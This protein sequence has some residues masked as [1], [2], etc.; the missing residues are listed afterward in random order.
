MTLIALLT[1]RQGKTLIADALISRP[2]PPLDDFVFPTRIYI[3]PGQIRGMPLKPGALRRKVIEISSNLV[4]LWAGDYNEAQRFAERAAEWLNGGTIGESDIVAFLEE[5]YRQRIPNFHAIIIPAH[6]DWFYQ[7]GDVSRSI[8]LFAG[9]YAVAGSGREIFRKMMDQMTPNEAGRLAPDFDGL[10][11]SSELLAQEI[12]TGAPFHSLFG[13][14]YEVLYRGLNGFERVD[15]VLYIFALAKVVP[16]A[17]VI[18][19][20][21][22]VIRQW[23]EDDQLCVASMSSPE[24]HRQGVEFRGFAIPSVLGTKTTQSIRTLESLAERPKYM[25]VF[26]VLEIEG[27]TISFVMTSKGDAIDQM[28]QISREGGMLVWNATNA[29]TELLFETAARARVELAARK[30]R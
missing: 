29:Y 27:E 26:H 30:T 15:D 2:D 4:A 8:S 18:S 20:Y 3:P 24:A 25:C 12:A 13:G 9:E 17:I 14:A 28:F 5:F 1:P 22:H 11:I 23:Y 10:R 21:H 16:D 7:I 19:H 6:Q